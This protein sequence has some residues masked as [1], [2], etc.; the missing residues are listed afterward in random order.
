M[1]RMVRGGFVGMNDT[2]VWHLFDL[3]ESGMM[4]RL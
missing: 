2:R 4:R 1:L 3:S